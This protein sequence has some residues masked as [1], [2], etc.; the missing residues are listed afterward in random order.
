MNRPASVPSLHLLSWSWAMPRASCRLAAAVVLTAAIGPALAAPQAFDALEVLGRSPESA[1]ALVYRGD[2]FAR[3]TPAGPPLYRYER[4]IVTGPTGQTARHITRDAAGTVIIMESSVAT[5]TQD[6]Q[7]CDVIDRQS[8]FTGSVELSLDGRQL[9]YERHRN[10]L[11]SKGSETVS[12]PVLCGPSMF[13]FVLRHWDPLAA[14]A[15]LPVRLVSIKD[16]TT[17]G[18]DLRFE[19]RADGL[20]SFTF[21][22]THFLIRLVF[23]PLRVS[24]DAET[25]MPVRYEGR[26]PPMESVAGK[27]ADLDARVEYTPVAAAYR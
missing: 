14:G 16:S 5:S 18:F 21:T 9:A 15:V 2:T 19:K 27:L 25:R 8:G 11:V 13:G 1:G 26:V 7:R 20:A 10:G 22:P 6:L 12:D 3:R 24:F 23:A 4:R 17:Y